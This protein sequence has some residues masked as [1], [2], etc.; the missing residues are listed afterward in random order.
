M[1]KEE[2]RS[3]IIFSV[4]F[5]AGLL[6]CFKVVGPANVEYGPE[7]MKPL[8]FI[9]LN[10][11]AA[12]L[13]NIIG[14]E[15]LHVLGAV[16]GGYSVTKVNILKFCIYKD[17]ENNWKFGYRDYDGLT[18]E[19]TIVPKKEKPNIK[20][21]IWCPLFGYA[22]ELASC[23]VIY[24]MI[25][26]GVTTGEVKSTWFA[27]SAL[28]LI[29]VSSLIAVYNFAPFKL[30]SMTDGYRLA[31]LNKE[32]NIKAYNEVLK[33]E[34]LHR[35][36]KSVENVTVFDE[37]TEYTASLN[38]IA[39]YKFLEKGDLKKANDVVSKLLEHQDILDEPQYNRLIAQKLY[40][41]VLTSDVEKAKSLYDELCPDKI[42]RF[43]A[44]DVSME[45]IRAYILIA[46]MIEESENE[47]LYAKSRVEK[48]MKRTYKF[49]ASVE[50]KLLNDAVEYVYKEHPKWNKENL[51][52]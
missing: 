52:K 28:I 7:K 46:G 44:N 26:K 21:Y 6:V 15:L 48:A 38:I 24:T 5:I 8:L 10:L 4:M 2:V 41:E 12:F 13:V 19:T 36:G 1:K 47:V 11:V 33:I 50:E 34:D 16:I 39:L 29:L 27:V 18:G 25:S 51:A 14:L 43:I 20:P 30:D 37:I 17:S 3:L 31:L 9:A 32:V 42:R 22:I 35:Q 45:S 23:I 49:Q 40:I